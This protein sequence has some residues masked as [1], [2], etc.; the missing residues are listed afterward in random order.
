M[1]DILHKPCPVCDEKG[2]LANVG[3]SL[4]CEC[5]YCNG[6]GK[7]SIWAKLKYS[8]KTMFGFR[9][10][11]KCIIRLQK[12]YKNSTIARLIKNEEYRILM[13]SLSKNAPIMQW[14]KNTR[15]VYTYANDTMAKHLFGFKDSDEIVG[16]TDEE[17]M[18]TIIEKYPKW[19]IG[20][21]CMVTDLEV[22]KHKKP[23]K[24][25]EWGYIKDK[26]EYIV[27]FKAPYYDK[28]EKLLGTTG[29]AIYVTDEVND[30]IEILSQTTDTNT[31]DQ[32]K[33][34]LERYGFGQ[35]NLYTDQHIEY[36]WEKR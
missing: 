18:N 8:I 12:L 1:G 24:F 2:T 4:S 25:Y 32:L 17:I 11:T 34:Y 27:S 30:M 13:Y 7:I 19:S 26:Y 22:L 33:K 21:I 14:A 23:M 15:G 20:N 29:V 31:R 5:P 35:E 9:D 28:N 6:S 10:D 36:L 3:D 16:R